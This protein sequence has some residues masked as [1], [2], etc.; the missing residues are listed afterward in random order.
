VTVAN[1]QAIT[2][3]KARYGALRYGANPT[4]LMCHP[5]LFACAGVSAEPSAH[6]TYTRK[7]VAVA[8]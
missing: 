8:L 5:R 1:A 6:L 3:L 2:V 7:P 4:Q